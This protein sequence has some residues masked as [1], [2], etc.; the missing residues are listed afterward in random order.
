MKMTHKNLLRCL[1]ICA[2]GLSGSAFADQSTHVQKKGGFCIAYSNLFSDASKFK[3]TCPDIAPQPITVKEIYDANWR[4]V[5]T[6]SSD[7][8]GTLNSLIVEQQ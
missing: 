8:K 2:I 1:T 6:I 5:G 3:F 4:V 7:G